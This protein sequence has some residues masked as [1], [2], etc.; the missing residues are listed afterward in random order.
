MGIYDSIM[1]FITYIEPWWLVF[2]ALILLI[3]SF[4]ILDSE[5][6]LTISGGIL[7]WSLALFIGAPPLISLISLPVCLL[8]SYFLQVKFY[9][10]ISVGEVPF[11]QTPNDSIGTSGILRVV[12]DDNSASSY[13]DK[14]YKSEISQETVPDSYETKVYRVLLS[15][16][17]AHDALPDFDGGKTGD[18]VK[19]TGFH[20]GL[21]LVTRV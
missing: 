5:F 18:R 19:I 12:T 10:S 8:L 9:R 21:A 15:D 6:L 4:T 3:I 11:E 2:F 16:G 14:K 7:F 20:N 13:Y 1:F 17:G